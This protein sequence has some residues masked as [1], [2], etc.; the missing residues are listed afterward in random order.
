MNH[1]RLTHALA[2]CTALTLLSP[3]AALAGDLNPPPGPIQ[4]TNRVQINQ[5]TIGA[6]PYTISQPGS[7]VLTSNI[8]GVSGADGIVITSRD[9]VL[10][11]NGFTLQ[12]VAGST[13]GIRISGNAVA[14]V[15]GRLRGWGAEGIASG[16]AGLVVRDVQVWE[17]GARGMN[18]G[19][20]ATVDN[21]VA[22]G[23]ADFGIRVGSSSVIRN[24]VARA[25]AAGGLLLLPGGVVTGSTAAENTGPGIS[26]QNGAVVE[27]CTVRAN[28]AEGLSVGANSSVRGVSAILNTL[29]GVVAGVGSSISDSV[30]SLNGGIGF[31]AFPGATIHNCNAQDNG[32]HGYELGR[33]TPGQT[34]VI[35]AVT[36]TG[37]TA[38]KNAGHGFFASNANG[39][40][41]FSSCS[42]FANTLNGFDGTGNY[43]ACQSNNNSENGFNLGNGSTITNSNARG[44]GQNGFSGGQGTTVVAC[45]AR[46]NKGFAGISVS[47][48]VIRDS[49]A[50]GNDRHG[51][52]VDRQALVIN[53]SCGQNG[54]GSGINDGAGI[55]ASAMFGGTGSRIEGNNVSFNDIGIRVVAGGNHI[56]RNTASGNSVSNYSLTGANNAGAI[57]VGAGAAATAGPWDNF[58]F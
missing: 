39:P 52:A 55:I 16:S 18:L 53:N 44:N 58:S 3:L 46:F 22:F 26:A 13:A 27:N 33:A 30:A 15:N 31:V 45:T 40:G 10:D 32:S 51:I 11:L 48:G 43:D 9:V 2:A 50:F 20:N 47:E 29:D 23:N 49:S 38:S 42:A 7:Y 6:F 37:S 1:R 12:G 4:P 17:N 28:T 19:N 56:L 54:V 57:L 8:T 14:V 24:S 41:L 5:Q 34:I 25:N 21:C 36:V 35:H